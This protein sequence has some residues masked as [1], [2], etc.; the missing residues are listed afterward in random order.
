[1]GLQ[2]VHGVMGSLAGTLTR[3]SGP[4]GLRVWPA[5]IARQAKGKEVDSRRYVDLV[6]VCNCRGC[7]DIH[8]GGTVLGSEHG[9]GH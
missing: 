3:L 8:I 4:P 5:R 6:G 9:A 1:M 7:P 2:H